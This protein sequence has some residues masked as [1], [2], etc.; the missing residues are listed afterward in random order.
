MFRIDFDMVIAE[1]SVKSF[2]RNFIL[3]LMIV[4]CFEIFESMK[5]TFRIPS[6][7]GKIIHTQESF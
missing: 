4:F 6:G 5:T 7:I 2:N 3:F 1:N